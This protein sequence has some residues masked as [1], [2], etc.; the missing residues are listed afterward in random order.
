MVR[1]SAGDVILSLPDARERPAAEPQTPPL[2]YP[3]RR[4]PILCVLSIS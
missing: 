2:S 1:V 4:E 3:R